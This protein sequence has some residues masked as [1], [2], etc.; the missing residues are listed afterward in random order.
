MLINPSLCTFFYRQ[1]ITSSSSYF[2]DFFSND[3]SGGK[4]LFLSTTA[5]I[6]LLAIQLSFAKFYIGIY[7]LKT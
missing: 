5:A 4:K 7:N 6:N 3:L 1:K 2:I